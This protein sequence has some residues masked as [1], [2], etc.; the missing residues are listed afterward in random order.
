MYQTCYNAL[1]YVTF[2]KE[3]IKYGNVVKAIESK[4][5]KN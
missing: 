5:G 2:A 3:H 4:F 1:L